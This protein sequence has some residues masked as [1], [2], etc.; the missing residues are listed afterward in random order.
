MPFCDLLGPRFELCLNFPRA[1]L[2]FPRTSSGYF[3]LTLRLLLSCFALAS[4][5]RCTLHRLSALCLHT[6]IGLPFV[7][8]LSVVVCSLFSFRIFIGCFSDHSLFFYYSLSGLARLSEQRLS[9]CGLR[10][11][12]AFQHRHRRQLDALNVLQKCA[13]AGRDIGY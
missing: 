6:R 7:C 8:L 12:P 2:G 1:F 10:C 11:P 9:G 3:R 4:A 13:A 5:L